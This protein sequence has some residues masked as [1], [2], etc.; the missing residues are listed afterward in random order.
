MMLKA[1]RLA[2]AGI[3][4]TLGF[5]VAALAASEGTPEPPELEWHHSGP[6]GTYDRAAA[7][8][9]MQVYKEVCSSCHSLRLVSFRNLTDLG[10]SADQVKSFAAEYEVTDGPDDAG[11][12]FERPG[13]PA[14]RFPSPFDNDKAARAANGGAL[15]PDL[16]LIV[17]AREGHEDYIHAILAGYS[18]PPADVELREGMHYNKY[19]PGGGIGMPPPL[20]DDQVEYSDGTP[21]TVDQMAKDVT[22]FLAWAA[23][24]KMEARKQTGIGVIIFLIVLTGLLYAV[25]R[26]V[27]SDLH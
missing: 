22:V 23:E 12:M 19:F 16:S 13:I 9:G 7:Q 27:W 15:P 24:P 4:L 21:A 10:Y 2:G 5:S 26:K 25:K 18:E 17:K 3:A 6:F 8:R 14:D 1:L 11:D 20:F